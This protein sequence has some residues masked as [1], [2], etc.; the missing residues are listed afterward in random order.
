MSLIPRAA[1]LH[2]VSRESPFQLVHLPSSC[3]ACHSSRD[4]RAAL[5]L[6]CSL[7]GPHG[8]ALPKVCD[9]RSFRF[10]IPWGELKD[11]AQ[12]RRLP[13][14]LPYMSEAVQCLCWTGALT[15]TLAE[16]Y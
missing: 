2:K 15:E 13:C 10:P 8:A 11:E 7:V 5:G 4:H 3:P 14:L 6:L 9:P 1:D 12:C 16:G